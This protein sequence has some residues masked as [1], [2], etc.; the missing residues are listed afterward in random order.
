MSNASAAHR[1]PL[2]VIRHII[3][4]YRADIQAQ[5]Y[6]GNELKKIREAKIFDSVGDEMS[7]INRVVQLSRTDPLRYLTSRT[8]KKKKKLGRGK[9]TKK[10]CKK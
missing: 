2:D 5:E 4:P 10:E 7:G 8:Y 1:I 3:L 9:S 6:K